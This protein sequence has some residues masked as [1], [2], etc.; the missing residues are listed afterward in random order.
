MS[1]FVFQG[2]PSGAWYI[3]TVAHPASGTKGADMAIMRRV[4]TFNGALQIEL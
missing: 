1:R 3:I 2:L 4:E